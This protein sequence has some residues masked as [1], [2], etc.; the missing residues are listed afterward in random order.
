M[1]ELI[2]KRLEEIREESR[3]FS[4]ATMRWCNLNLNVGD[5]TIHISEVKWDVF[6]D[7]KLLNVF[8]RVIR[9]NTT[10]M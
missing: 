8:E 5:E 7:E 2:E 9:R 6:T 3:N 4:K 1:R 10:Q